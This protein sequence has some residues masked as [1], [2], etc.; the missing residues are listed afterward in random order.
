[1]IGGDV[2]VFQ[3]VCLFR[4]SGD[5][6]VAD[7]GNPFPVIEGAQYLDIHDIRIETLGMG[8]QVPVK[9][10]LC[11]VCP[12]RRVMEDCSGIEDGAVCGSHRDQSFIKGFELFLMV[13]Q[14]EGAVAGNQHIQVL[15]F[16]AREGFLVRDEFVQ[17]AEESADV[18]SA[19]ENVGLAEKSRG[20]VALKFQSLEVAGKREAVPAFGILM[21]TDHAE[22][23]R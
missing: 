5:C 12:A 4:E 19:V 7:T 18:P 22:D 14:E 11:L 8:F 10:V 2:L 3:E 17:A 13:V 9:E 21:V 20:I 16:D 15:G 23:S 6:A 1:M